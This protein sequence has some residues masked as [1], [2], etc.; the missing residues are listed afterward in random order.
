MLI[1]STY[2][3][4]GYSIANDITNS[5]VSSNIKYSLMNH[6]ITASEGSN[7]KELTGVIRI[8]GK[9]ITELIGTAD[10]VLSLFYDSPL[11]PYIDSTISTLN[12][13][14]TNIYC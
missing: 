10:N 13:K 6:Y 8:R 5:I 12:K 4:N 11:S 7:T 3:Y 14:A 9:L 2:L 1:R